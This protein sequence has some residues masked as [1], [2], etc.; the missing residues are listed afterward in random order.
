[1][2]NL[3]QY[4][5]IVGSEVIVRIKEKAKPLLN[6]HIVCINSTFS[7]GGVAEM[8][9]SAVFLFN[10]LGLRFGWRILQG[11]P[12]FFNITKKLH[13]ALQ[14]EKINLSEEEKK[15]FY[16][17]NERFAAFTHLPHDLVIIHDPQP[18]PL[19]DFFEKSQPWIWRCHVDMSEP[20]PATWNY[21]KGFVEKYDE[22]IVS[23][24]E[25]KQ[26]LSIPQNLIHPAIDPLTQKNEDISEIE[27]EKYLKKFGI[28]LNKPII[29]QVS[30][31]DKWKDPKGVVEIFKK[32]RAQVDCQ[33]VLLGSF[34]ADDPEGQETFEEIEK[35]IA[36]CG[37][38]DDVIL[39]TVSDDILVNCL[40]RAAAVVIQKSLREG[41]GLTVAEALYKGTPVIASRVGGIPLQITDGKSGF[42]HEPQDLEGFTASAIELIKDTD[43]QKKLGE[44]GKKH[45]T[46]N[47]LITRYIEDW[48]D[49]FNRH[50]STSN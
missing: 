44:Q 11:F 21:L 5:S 43:L 45:V 24:E 14:G 34:A 47:F 16:E 28:N 13:H 3:E 22:I 31:Y 42:L 12:S 48:L 38:E 7:G 4:E 40:Q 46:E 6:R 33:L 36:D 35:C 30:R 37:Y 8:L 18:L 19:I 1:M 27:A 10:K 49:L 32:V 39:L 50:L 25:Y 9:N 15:I 29:T 20:D 23:Q 2:N 26:N 41:F 17:T